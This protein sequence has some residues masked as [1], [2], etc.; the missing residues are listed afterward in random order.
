MPLP[1]RYDAARVLASEKRP[2]LAGDRRKETVKLTWSGPE[3][4]RKIWTPILGHSSAS[5]A[6]LR[7]GADWRW[8]VSLA[9][10]GEG[11]RCAGRAAASE[12]I[13]HEAGRWP[14]QR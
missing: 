12:A 6:S 14:G 2:S 4:G 3:T 1:W 8:H 13:A 9:Q 7:V 11:E 10:K 5:A